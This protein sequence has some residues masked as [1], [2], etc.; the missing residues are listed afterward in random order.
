[1][2]APN[3]QTESDST[4]SALVALHPGHITLPFATIGEEVDSQII[5]TSAISTNKYMRVAKA[6]AKEP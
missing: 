4:A 2:T 6:K 5:A 3:Q 1:M